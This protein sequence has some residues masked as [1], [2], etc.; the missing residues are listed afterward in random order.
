MICS[1]Q[2]PRLVKSVFE[3]SVKSRPLCSAKTMPIQVAARSGDTGE[4]ARAVG[5]AAKAPSPR[6]GSLLAGRWNPQ[7]APTPAT[8][9]TNPQA[10]PDGN[11]ATIKKRIDALTE[12][13]IVPKDAEWL[14]RMDDKDYAKFLELMDE[15]EPSMFMNALNFIARRAHQHGRNEGRADTSGGIVGGPRP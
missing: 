4:G 1:T 13:G 11:D 6:T 8:A 3:A 9:P 14:A 2:V 10:Q 12:A 5:G 15:K 7:T